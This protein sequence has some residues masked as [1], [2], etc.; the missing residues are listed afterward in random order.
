MNSKSLA[1]AQRTCDAGLGSYLAQKHSDFRMKSFSKGVVAG[2][3]LTI[4]TYFGLKYYGMNPSLAALPFF[5]GTVGG[6]YRGIT[7]AEQDDTLHTSDFEEVCSS[8]EEDEEEDE[9]TSE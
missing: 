3:I 2:V 1:E 6:T 9:E 8:L 5:A 7:S 4:P